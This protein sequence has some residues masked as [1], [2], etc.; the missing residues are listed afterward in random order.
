[1]SKASLP[2]AN[3]AMLELFDNS[4]H[5][6][7]LRWA[8][9]DTLRGLKRSK[10]LAN[11]SGEPERH[12]SLRPIPIVRPDSS[13]ASKSRSFHACPDSNPTSTNCASLRVAKAASVSRKSVEEFSAGCG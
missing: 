8:G 10:N 5:S 13:T 11:P 7:E 9:Q 3:T 1:P 12:S 2:G 6:S 4:E